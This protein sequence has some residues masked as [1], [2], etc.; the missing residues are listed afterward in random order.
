MTDDG[1]RVLAPEITLLF[2]ARID[3]T[4]DRRDLAR[5]LPLLDSD[6]RAWLRERVRRLWPEHRWL[7]DLAD[8]S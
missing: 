7:S 1:V 4:K 5:A 3:R 2:K 6:Q 8:P